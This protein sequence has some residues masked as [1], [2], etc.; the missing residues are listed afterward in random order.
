MFHSVIGTA[1]CLPCSWPSIIA[2]SPATATA[3]CAAILTLVGRGCPQAGGAGT[4]AE[5][6]HSCPQ[7]RRTEVKLSNVPIL[8]SIR[9]LLRT[10]MSALR[11]RRQN[12][13]ALRRLLHILIQTGGAGTKAERGHSCPQQRR[14]EVKLSNVTILL[15]IRELLRTRMS[16]LR[17][18][19][20]NLRAL[21]RL[22]HILIQR[23]G[24]PSQRPGDSTT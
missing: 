20:R 4:T 8:L 2:I 12:L 15:S 18:R 22:L 14:T 6:G 23:A 21:R 13:R 11:W 24:G 1:G 3:N 7:Q 9:E 16:A 17:C 5:H 10:R 19:P